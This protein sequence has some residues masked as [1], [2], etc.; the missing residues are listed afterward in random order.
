M[1]DLDALIEERT[2]RELAL[3]GNHADVA[4]GESKSGV[5]EDAQSSADRPT[6]LWPDQRHLVPRRC[7]HCGANRANFETN[8]PYGTVKRGEI[9]CWVC[10]RLQVN[11]KDAGTQSSPARSVPAPIENSC[12]ACGERPRAGDRTICGP[13]HH[14]RQ[15]GKDRARSA[16][17]AS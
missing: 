12:A 14:A 17:G 8:E 9:T 16:G 5:R 3:R 7:W 13:C 11:L 10:S 1:L 4:H 15:R 2:R 6:I